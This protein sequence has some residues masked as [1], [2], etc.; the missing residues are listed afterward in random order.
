MNYKSMYLRLKANEK[1]FLNGA[2]FRADRRVTL[3]LMNNATF[4]LE[5]HILQVEETTTPLKQL[6]FAG[7]LMLM[8]PAESQ[9]SRQTFAQLLANLRAVVKDAYLLSE[10]ERCASLFEKKR[11]FEILKLLRRLFPYE[12]ELMRSAPI[13]M[14]EVAE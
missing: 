9:P 7:Q 13:M 1:V 14:P 3:E 12:E 6:Y 5:S 2:V 11:I 10:L 4:L 8:N